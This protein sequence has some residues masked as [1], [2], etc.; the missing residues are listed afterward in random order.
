MND[1]APLCG[2]PPLAEP[3]RGLKLAEPPRGTASQMAHG[4]ASP[5]W[6]AARE[7]RPAAPPP[8]SRATAE[9]DSP[10]IRS[11]RD[12]LRLTLQGWGLDAAEDEV[13]LA[14]HELVVNA[15][16][17]GCRGV[18]HPS[19]TVALSA[20]YGEATLRVAVADP[21]REL[22]QLRAESDEA[23]AGRGLHLV[24]AVVDRWGATPETDGLPKVV[25]FE[26]DQ[27][28]GGRKLL[29]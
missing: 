8:P 9:A 12:R 13:A 3:T 27:P 19:S 18:S 20:H 21:A 14:D 26:L 28:I 11:T 10:A 22:P 17:P 4:D 24:R 29:A 6:T 5:G 25:W 7:R 15:V 23:E 1:L 16:T 2:R